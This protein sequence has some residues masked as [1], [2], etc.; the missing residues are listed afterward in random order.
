M[1]KFAKNRA[2]VKLR[3]AIRTTITLSIV[4]LCLGIGMYSFLRL[5]AYD[6][7][8][9]FNLYTL[10]PQDAIAVLE[11]D[12]MVD[13]VADVNAFEHQNNQTFYDAD[14]FIL[15]KN[16]LHTF[17][18]D[19]PHGLSAQMNKMLF[20]FHSF[21]HS[22]HQLF[23][24]T[25]H[26][27]DYKLIEAFIEKQCSSAFPSKIFD[28]NGEE[29]RIYPLQDD[30]FLA[31]YVTRDFLV[32]SYQ[33]RLVEQV[34]DAYQNKSS[35]Q[36]DTAFTSIHG[37]KHAHSTTLYLR[38][39]D[40]AFGSLSSKQDC[41]MNLGEWMELDLK[42]GSDAIYCSGVIHEPDSLHPF[43]QAISAQQAIPALEGNVMPASTTLY[44]SWGLSSPEVLFDLLSQAK[45][46]TVQTDEVSQQNDYLLNFLQMHA[47]H[48]LSVCQFH[49][50][51][52]FTSQPCV[53]LNIPLLDRKE[54][55]RD[56]KE[57][58]VSYWSKEYRNIRV[59]QSLYTPS[60]SSVFR[61]Y[62]IPFN[63]LWNQFTAS[64][65]SVSGLYAICYADAL[66]MAPDVRSLLMYVA[67]I[68]HRNIFAANRSCYEGLMGSL[69]VMDNY[70][71]L[72]D[73]DAMLQSS[74][75]T[76]N[77]LPQLFLRQK[78]FFRRFIIAIQLLSV[79]N[80]IY[81][82]IVLLNK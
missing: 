22:D 13:F 31:L 81:P 3:F 2:I 10:V 54:A 36:D 67:E 53:I 80:T 69:S 33:K 17:I 5:N 20:S 32:A 41:S 82:N 35:L 4:L 23:Y 72:L 37:I 57:W 62:K 34:I 7:H 56:L 40:V 27:D 66:L 30:R 43:I 18:N 73:L 77:L 47:K 26:P 65:S 59:E 70:L 50:T 76:V 61:Y 38:M 6:E 16:Y 45:S 9:D 75:P 58:E 1:F 28:Y 21:N 79:D 74:M 42:I 14:L 49:P 51:D 11:T 46:D 15:L 25:L 78:D 24:C 44:T 60:S 52:T 8:R 48:S 68:E 55:E 64:I 19:V 39:K 63:T 12:C 29:I 71:M